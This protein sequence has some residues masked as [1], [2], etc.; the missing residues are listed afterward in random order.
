MIIRDAASA[1]STR[2]AATMRRPGGASVLPSGELSTLIGYHG[3]S[4]GHQR[5]NPPLRAAS[6]AFLTCRYLP[7][8]QCHCT[9][10]TLRLARAGR[11]SSWQ[12]IAMAGVPTSSPLRHTSHEPW[13]RLLPRT[14]SPTHSPQLPTLCRRLRPM[15]TSRQAGAE[16]RCHEP[17]SFAWGAL[18]DRARR[19]AHQQR[20][21]ATRN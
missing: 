1:A 11:L 4:K 7:H 17:A 21:T 14:G 10:A 20:T 15:V 9:S 6:H 2:L 13:A 8:E 12:V 19:T 18:E 16:C 3:C 5:C